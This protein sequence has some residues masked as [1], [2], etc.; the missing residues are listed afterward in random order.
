VEPGETTAK[1]VEEDA[2]ALT[3]QLERDTPA[4]KDE[5]GI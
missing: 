3:E 2:E 1:Q 5:G 4:S